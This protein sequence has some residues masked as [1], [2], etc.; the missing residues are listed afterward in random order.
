MRHLIRGT[1]DSGL[2]VRFAPEHPS[3][4]GVL[5]LAGSSGRV[6]EGRAELFAVRTGA[7]AES[8]RWFGGPGQQ[9]GPWEIPLEMFTA[10]VEA[11]SRECDRVVVV[12]TSFGAEAALLVGA[13]DPGVDAVVACAPTDVVWAGV[14]PDGSQTSHW[15]LGGRGLAHVRFDEGWRADVDPPAY[16]GL[17]ETSRADA[18]R[19]GSA[20]AASIPVER[21]RELMLVA[22][23]DDQVWPSAAMARSIVDRRARHGH[24]TDLVMLAGAG[25]RCLLPGEE[26]AKGGVTMQRGGTE[27]ADRRLGARAWPGIADLLGVPVRK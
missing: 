21:I 26:P 1:L 19:A 13:L 14:R 25:H 23:G 15:T 27:E 16:V 12:G 6:D 5:V 11:L 7:I 4:V 17:Y 3:G 9:T 10:R 24:A 22:G 20:A 18:E 8:I 2:G